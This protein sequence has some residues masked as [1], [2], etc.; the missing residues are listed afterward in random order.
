MF[1]KY[2]HNPT[3]NILVYVPTLIGL[4]VVIYGEKYT[5]V[6]EPKGQTW[7]FSDGEQVKSS[8]VR[9]Y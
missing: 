2:H 6:S 8:D 5:S 7:E 3:I 9:H 1:D 4:N